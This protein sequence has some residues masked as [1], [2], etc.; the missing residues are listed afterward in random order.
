MSEV[1]INVSTNGK[2]IIADHACLRFH[3]DLPNCEM[4]YLHLSI[5]T[6]TRLIID[7][8]SHDEMIAFCEKHNF[9]YE[10]RRQPKDADAA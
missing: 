10:D 1:R 7:F 3:S 2:P 4:A 5:G 8:D 6:A 9:E